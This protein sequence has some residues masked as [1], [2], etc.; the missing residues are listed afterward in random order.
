MNNGTLMTAPVSRVAGLLPPGGGGGG[1][2]VGQG[3]R[4]STHRVCVRC[5]ACS[6]GWCGACATG[7]VDFTTP[8]GLHEM[9]CV[10][11]TMLPTASPYSTPS[12]PFLS[13]A[14]VGGGRGECY[15]LPPARSCLLLLYTLL[16]TAFPPQPLPALCSLPLLTAGGCVALHAGRRLHHGQ[17]H[18]GGRL[19]RD[20]LPGGVGGGGWDGGEGGRAA[21]W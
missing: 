12:L 5:L 20:D 7:H 6:C 1:G 10:D 13:S 21:A 19:N 2:W 11:H 8:T 15:A 4:G 14:G 16:L 3:G 17:V 18:E 9:C